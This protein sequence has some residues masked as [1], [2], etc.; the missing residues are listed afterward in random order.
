MQDVGVYVGELVCLGGHSGLELQVAAI[1]RGQDGMDLLR[2][3]AADV[4]PKHDAVGC[5]TAK[6]LHLVL[7]AR[8]KWKMLT[9]R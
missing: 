7:A 8:K 9:G 6:V 5:L 4:R 2:G 3:V 1:L